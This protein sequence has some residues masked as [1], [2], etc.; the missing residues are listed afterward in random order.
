MASQQAL[1]DGWCSEVHAWVKPENAA[2]IKAFERAG[3]SQKE[4]QTP[5]SQQATL[6]VMSEPVRHAASI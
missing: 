6:F 3:F 4:P 1:A 5:H 2:S